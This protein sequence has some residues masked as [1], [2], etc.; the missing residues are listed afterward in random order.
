M[1]SG[2]AAI[3]AIASV[4]VIYTLDR[5]RDRHI[6]A[7]EGAPAP[8]VVAAFPP[9]S[10]VNMPRCTPVIV[11]LNTPVDGR[12][13][14][15][16][17]FV[18][19]DGKR[20]DLG[21]DA[22]LSILDGDRGNAIAVLMP[23]EPFP[24]GARITGAIRQYRA[25]AVPAVEAAIDFTVV[26]EELPMPALSNLSFAASTKFVGRGD[27]GLVSESESTA[28]TRGSQILALST[29][30]VLGRQAVQQTNSL[31]VIGPVET[32]SASGWR[33]FGFGGRELTLEF[34]YNFISEEFDE[35][36]G[37]AFDD[38]FIVTLSGPDRG[39]AKVVTSVNR[40]GLDGSS[41]TD[42]AAASPLDD[43]QETS[44]QTNSISE[45]VGGT[46]CIGFFLS[47]VGDNQYTSLLA[48]R[49]IHFN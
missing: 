30:E 18:T 24:L 32:R 23:G 11:F 22:H 46:A 19:E 9:A 6:E 34:S 14:Y 2:A 20:T 17:E 31:I 42:F 21:G 4:T 15:D 49:D 29:G 3:A 37:Q 43:A 45:A 38:T 48:L 10:G 40:I 44:W 12:F 13:E 8:A 47:D 26:A 33:F 28:T 36:V 41:P 16:L 27:T 1:A 5:Q 35:Y 7:L 39:I 25:A